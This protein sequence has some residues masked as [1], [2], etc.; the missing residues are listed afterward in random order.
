MTNAIILLS[1]G[2]DSVVSLASIRSEYSEILALTFN[3]GQ[4]SFIAEKN[5]AEKIA[6]FYNIKHKIIDL[7]WLSEISTSSLNTI[8][9]VP[10][11]SVSDLEQV[12]LTHKSSK[13][14]WVPNRN[15]LF[16]NIA[17]TF[18]EALGYDVVII[19]ANKEEALTFKDNSIE[20]INAIN[21]SYKNSMNKT[22]K[23]IAPLIE[24]NKSEI[25]NKGIKLNI[26]FDLINSCYVSNINH[27]GQCESCVRLIRALEQNGAQDIIEV[28]FKGK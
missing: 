11:L 2:L 3:Y 16:V 7:G 17:G 22:V 6:A 19:G 9:D 14:V 25:V 8:M 15:G 24:L 13:S 4:K 23:L 5:A 28:I 18:A 26:P 10:S 20:F 1:G 12:E 27:C 21:N